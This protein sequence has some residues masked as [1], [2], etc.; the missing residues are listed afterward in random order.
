MP[1][2]KYIVSLTSEERHELEQLVNTGRAAAYRI[3]H[4]RILLKANTQQ[5]DGGWTDAAISEALDIS[6]ATIER[7]RQRFV[8]HGVTAALGRKKQQRHR[9]RRLDGEQE[10]HL[11]ALTCSDP[12]PGHSRWTLRLL[13]ERMVTLEQVDT[14]SHETVRQTLKKTNSNLG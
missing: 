9:S 12:P 4:A 6:V 7:V 3:N 8:E 13:A 5:S 14:L 11:V 10:A 1:A 2:K